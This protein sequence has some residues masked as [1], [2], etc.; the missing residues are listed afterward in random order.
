[1]A[2]KISEECISCGACV[3]SC[4]VDAISEGDG[5]YVIDPE[6]CIDCG[7]CAGVCPVDAPQEA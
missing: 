6:T 4:P 1:M 3:D 2:Y 5:I 7:A